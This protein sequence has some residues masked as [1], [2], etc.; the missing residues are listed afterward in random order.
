[1]KLR[2][3]AISHRQPAWVTEGCADYE[4][5]LPREWG[6]QVVDVKPGQRTGSVDPA[7]VRADEA[8]RVRAV[9]PRGCRVVGLDERGTAWSTVAFAERLGRW[10]QE[11]RDVAFVIGGADGL[12]PAFA[13]GADQRWSLSAMT[14][15]HGLVRVV[16]VEQLYRAATILRGHPYHK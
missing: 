4:K 16:V 14:L 11:G 13:A 3:V 9:L 12:D 10:Q 15:P 6:F 7:K 8:D 5:R 1:M 2:L